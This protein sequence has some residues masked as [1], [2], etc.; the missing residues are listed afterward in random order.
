MAIRKR[1]HLLLGA[2]TIVT[3][4]LIILAALYKDVQNMKN[5]VEIKVDPTKTLG[6]FKDLR[7]VNCGPLSSRGWDKK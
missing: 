6:I 2:C 5:I 7:G 4:F 3:I 1:I